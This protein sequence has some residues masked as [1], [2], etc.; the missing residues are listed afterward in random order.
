MHTYRDIASF[1]LAIDQSINRGQAGLSLTFKSSVYDNRLD[2]A[3][4]DTNLGARSIA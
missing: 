4:Y 2:L 3:N 1:I